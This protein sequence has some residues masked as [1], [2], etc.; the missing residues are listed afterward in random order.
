GEDALYEGGLSVRTTL[1]PKLQLE[2]RE[3]LHRGLIR[4]DTLRGFRGPITTIDISGDWGKPL[5]EVDGMS[6]VPEWRIAVVLKASKDSIT[7]GLQPQ[8]LDSGE[9]SPERQTGTISLED[10]A[11]AKRH[12]VD[13]K[14]LKAD[15]ADDILKPGDVIYAEKKPD[16]ENAWILR[17]KP[18][19]EG[20]LVAMDPHTGRV[21]AMVGGFSFD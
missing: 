16:A 4:Y 10:M 18:E 15:S 14:R 9:L 17:Q 3:A 21:L 5:A 6:D 11:W 8:R 7:I 12:I 19:I 1:D 20:A 13:G 2:A